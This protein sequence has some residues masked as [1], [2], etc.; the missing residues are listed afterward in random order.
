MLEHV[1]GYTPTE[2]A[3]RFSIA[4][5]A[6]VLILT[7]AIAASSNL[8]VGPQIVLL[9]PLTLVL[10]LVFALRRSFWSLVCFGYPFTLGLISAWIGYMEMPGY[11]QSPAFAVFIGIGLVGRSGSR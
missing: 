1:L 10:G 6:L 9:V 2:P 11:E 5:A 7:V 8:M 3:G 4:K